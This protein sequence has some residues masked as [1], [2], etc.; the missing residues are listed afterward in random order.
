[1]PSQQPP[2]YLYWQFHERGFAQAV[3]VG[4]WKGV[5]LDV[6]RRIELYDLKRDLTERKD[7]AANHPD[8]RKEI[9]RL[10]ET[11]RTESAEFPIIPG[12]GRSSRP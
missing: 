8:V 1:M 12:A 4:D 9:A 10:M 3:R 6:G 7:A 5:R 11:F 2:A